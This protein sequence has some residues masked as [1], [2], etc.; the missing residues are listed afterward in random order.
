MDLFFIAIVLPFIDI[1]IKKI[2]KYIDFLSGFFFTYDYTFKKHL[3]L[4]A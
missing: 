3:L 4:N 2:M 1:H